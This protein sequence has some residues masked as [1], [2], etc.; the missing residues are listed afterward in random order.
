M[1]LTI[2]LEANTYNAVY[3][4]I[5][6]EF[7]S[8]VAAD[9][10]IGPEVEV[11]VISNYNGYI[12]IYSTLAPHGLLQ[13]DYVKI[14]QDGGLA[15]FAGIWIVTKV[16]DTDTFVINAPYTVAPS[17]QVWYFKYLNNYNAIIRVYGY[18]ECITN[19]GLIAKIQLKPYFNNG[20]C[21][22]YIDI[23]DILKDFNSTCNTT[24][25]MTSNLFPLV[26]PPTI[27]N[28]FNSFIKYYISYAEGFDNPVGNEAEYIETGASDL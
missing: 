18:F 22:F 14:S 10:T 11:E 8:D 2:E 5:V 28:N 20:Y 9:Y 6:Y 21:W 13:G 3:N 25:G 26:S 12:Q 7:S 19:Y 15:G 17:G 24:E 4:P 23:S 27:Q 1:S 16:I